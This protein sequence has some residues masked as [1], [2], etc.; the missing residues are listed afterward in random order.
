MYLVSLIFSLS[1]FFSPRDNLV[2]DYVV[3][4]W[5]LTVFCYLYFHFPTLFPPVTILSYFSSMTMLCH[6]GSHLHCHLD[7]VVSFGFSLMAGLVVARLYTAGPC[8][9]SSPSPI[10]AGRS[11]NV[12]RRENIF[13]AFLIFIHMYWL[14]AETQK[15]KTFRSAEFHA[16][17][18][19]GWS[20]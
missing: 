5:V 8:T 11:G 14:E 16:Q 18:L 15:V 7:C 1:N 9:G 3:S 17:K 10:Y 6:L 13:E 20:A 19:S 2:P 12:P 4:F